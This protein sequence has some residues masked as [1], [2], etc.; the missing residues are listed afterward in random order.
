MSAAAAVMLCV[1]AVAA[2]IVSAAGMIAVVLIV[3]AAAVATT[4]TS[5]T[6]TAIATANSFISNRRCGCS[7]SVGDIFYRV[8]CCCIV[9]SRV[10]DVCYAR[11]RCCCRSR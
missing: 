9:H 3:V 5:T 1:A 7:I 2:A 4:T 11:C 6:G 8:F 10:M